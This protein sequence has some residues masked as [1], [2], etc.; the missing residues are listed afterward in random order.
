MKLEQLQTENSAA[1]GLSDLTDALEALRKLARRSHYHCEDP[2][3]SCPKAEDGSAN[4]AKG[5]DCDC[6]ADDHNAN[7]ELVFAEAMR[8]AS[9]R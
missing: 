8:I 7:V 5:N 1:G 3:Y 2:W 9:N 6:G 4:D